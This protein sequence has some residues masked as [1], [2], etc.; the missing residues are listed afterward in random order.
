MFSIP[1][2][3]KLIVDAVFNRDY[4][5]VQGVVLV[6]ATDLHRAEPARRPGLLLV[7]PRLRLSDEPTCAA[8]APP[9]VA[10]RGRPRSRARRG[11]RWRRLMRAASGAM[12]GLV[13]DRA[14][15]RCWRCSR[16]DRARTT[17]S[18]TELDAVR[19]APSRGALVRHRRDRPRRA[20][21][22]HL[23]C[24][25]LAAGRASSR[26]R[27]RS[28]IGVPLGLLAGLR[29]RL[30]RCGLISRITDA[31]LAVPVPDPRDRAG[32]LPRARA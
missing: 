8:R 16:P 29:R 25:R 2:F 4:A 1:G 27:S 20:V 3:G 22:R 7:N 6:T 24:A 5:V 9:R 15:R 21:A 19:K 13:V 14:V 10:D 23:G 30:D 11:A 17:R 32:R 28:C 31:M 12:F 18:Q 26:W